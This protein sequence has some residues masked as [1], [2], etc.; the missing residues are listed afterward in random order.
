MET[1]RSKQRFTAASKSAVQSSKWSDSFRRK[2]QSALILFCPSPLRRP[3]VR[4]PKVPTAVA[5]TTTTLAA[6]AAVAPA[7]S[8]TKRYEV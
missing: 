5:A 2:W 4:R 7:P 3:K 8:R 1:L 6:A